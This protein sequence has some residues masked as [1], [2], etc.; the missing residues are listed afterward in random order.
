MSL[1]GMTSEA[2]SIR[3]DSEYFICRRKK[4]LSKVRAINVSS[5][6]SERRGIE[7]SYYFC[8]YCNYYHVGRINRRKARQS[9]EK[10]AE[11]MPVR[12][13]R[14]YGQK[15]TWCLLAIDEEIIL[16]KSKDSNCLD[17]RIRLGL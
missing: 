11:S 10:V 14:Q 6:M 17:C 13:V 9:H 8:P 7:Y 4:R 2:K 1:V 5:T 15:R 3:K 16:V 12:H